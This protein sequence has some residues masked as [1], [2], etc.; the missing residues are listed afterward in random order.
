MLCK[1][2]RGVTPWEPGFAD[3]RPRVAR[4]AFGP[5]H[6]GLNVRRLFA[7]LLLLC[8]VL[9]LCAAPPLFDKSPRP[10][11][12]TAEEKRWLAAHP[13]IRIAPTD[14][15][16]PVEFFDSGRHYWGISAEYFNLIERR[17]DYPFNIISL[18]PAQWERPDPAGRGTDVMTASI[19]TPAQLQYWTFT[20]PYLSLPTYIIARRNAKENLTLSRLAGMRVTAIQRSAVEEYLRAQFPNIEV[21]AVPEAGTALRKVSFGLVDACVLTL[22]LATEWMQIEGVTNLKVVGEAGFTNHVSIAVR[23]D[24][25]E[26]QSILD[27]A[28]ATVTKAERKG[29]YERWV[30]LKLPSSNSHWTRITLWIGAGLLGILSAVIIWNRALASKVRA[31]TAAVRE[32]LARREAIVSLMTHLSAASTPTDAARFIFETADHFW[33]W[34]AGTLDMYSQSEDR[35]WA[36]IYLD[37][38]EGKRR[39]VSPL[40]PSYLLTPRMRRVMER[41]PELILRK[42]SEMQVSDSVPFGDTSRLSASIMSVPLRSHGQ[43]VGVLSIQSYTPNAF[44]NADLKLLQALADHCG[45]TLERIRVTQA[46]RQ[47]QEQFQ[48]LFES[49]PLATAIY[50]AKD[51]RLMNVNTRCLE[52]FGYSR[53]EVIGRTGLELGLWCDPSARDRML[54]RLQREEEVRDFEAQLRGKDGREFE[55]LLCAQRIELPAGPMVMIQANDITARKLAEADRGRLL[56]QLLESEDEERRRIARDLHDT[57][58]QHLAATKMNLTRLR[59]ANGKWHATEAQALEDSMALIEKSIQEIRTLTY[60]LH[61]PLLEELGLAGASRDYAAGFA[62]RS[63]VR[64]SVD[65]EGFAGRLPPALELALFRVVQ[66]SLGNVHRHSGSDTALIRLERDAEEV[67]LEIQDNG[68]GL[69]ANARAG[70]GLTSMRERLQQLGGRLEIESD[71]EGTTVL[72]SLPL[73]DAGAET[74]S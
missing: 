52:L 51:G 5:R 39:E 66:E 4:G 70:V 22:P 31:R 24:W 9:P 60:L 18:T 57:T 12:L 30:K 68:H 50:S 1:L 20:K 34:D 41:G 38:I 61:P 13:G 72:A 17:L 37:R 59:A 40:N 56:E 69:S 15:C 25:P 16:E 53:E 74:G 63:G 73:D 3:N 33:Q 19:M 23:N 43:C 29:I 54:D 47:S 49:S 67:R 62:Q 64:V 32:E 44:T 10:D 58:A 42:P 6:G 14:H 71:A 36:V 46:L 48:Q 27:K 65:V 28:L 55:L 21:D 8:T 35:V 2:P 45:D 26:L 7:A 11:L